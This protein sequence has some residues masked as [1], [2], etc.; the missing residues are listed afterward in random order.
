MKQTLTLNLLT[1][2]AL[3]LSGCATKTGKERSMPVTQ[4]N[5]YLS[6]A[7]EPQRFDY[8][9]YR[10]KEGLSCI[11]SP[12]VHAGHA[13]ETKLY[14]DGVPIIKMSGLSKYKTSRFL[15][16]TSTP[17]NWMEFS[18]SQRLS[19]HFIGVNGQVCP[20][21]GRLNIGSAPAYMAILPQMRLNQLFTENVPFY[22]RMAIGS[23]GPLNRGITTPRVDA[24]LGWDTLQQYETIQI[25]FSK[26]KLLIAA[27]EPYEPLEDAVITKAL[28]KKISGY[29]LAVKG[30]IDNEPTPIIIDTAGD[31]YLSRGDKKTRTTG[32]IRLGE[33]VVEN[34]PTELLPLHNAPPRVGR[35]FLENYLV[36][37]CGKTGFV[38]FEHLPE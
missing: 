37:I 15:I 7:K 8:Q 14:K 6:Q 16:D 34:V 9:V 36:T 29:G 1:V 38:Y 24:V 26:R 22:V 2:S 23:I 5:T 31:Y 28:I 21:G 18:T 10:G 12:R 3:L 25:N 17:F 32:Q 33:M 11:G 30:A 20:Y 35:K 13:A 19:T 27:T 4:Q